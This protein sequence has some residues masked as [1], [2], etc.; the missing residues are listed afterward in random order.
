MIRT[1]R[2]LAAAALLCAALTQSPIAAA[3]S[4]SAAR[5]SVVLGG[6]LV[7]AVD[8]QTREVTIR[9]DD[10]VIVSIIAGDEVRNFDQ[11]DVG[12]RIQVAFYEGV[13]AR[14]ADPNDPGGAVTITDS[15]R[16][17]LGDKPS[18]AIGQVTNIVIEF[19]EF[20]PE[21]SIVTYR[22]PDGLIRLRKIHPK[23]QDFAASRKEGDR[24]EVTIE[25]AIAVEVTELEGS[26]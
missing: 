22:R 25:Q 12:D 8:P 19:I 6:G 24:I 23:M 21:T 20:N 10:D 9:R 15:E 17:E 13:L 14:M 18:G 11:I 4:D 5:E 3:G 7:E 1:S 16:A 26:Q 2:N